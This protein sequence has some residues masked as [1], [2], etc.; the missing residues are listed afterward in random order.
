MYFTS[1]T[2]SDRR[3][4]VLNVNGSSEA[5]GSKKWLVSTVSICPRDSEGN[6]LDQ[7]KAPSS[8]TLCGHTTRAL[9]VVTTQ[10]NAQS[11]SS[12]A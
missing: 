11:S 10:R 5:L 6:T 9:G 1:S 12:D 8:F 3:A 2:S 7:I 4:K